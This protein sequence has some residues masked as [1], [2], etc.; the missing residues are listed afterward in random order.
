MKE[1]RGIDYVM[2]RGKKHRILKRGVK[3]FW[4]PIPTGIPESR[5]IS[6]ELYSILLWKKALE[7]ELSIRLGFPVTLEESDK[8]P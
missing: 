8:A 4:K 5:E 3:A 7:L 2:C 6:Y 1:K